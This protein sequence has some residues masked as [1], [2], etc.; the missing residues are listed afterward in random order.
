VAALVLVRLASDEHTAS[1][2][3]V[4]YGLSYA[5]GA[6]LSYLTLSRRVGG[7]RTRTLVRFLVRLLLA[8]A[9]AV[10]VAGGVTLVARH[11]PAADSLLGSVLQCAVIGAVGLGMLVVLARALRI[12]EVTEVVDTFARR[13]R[14]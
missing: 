13:L 11:V 14:R 6:T 7:L 4:A 5:V 1:A 9:G 3:T 8:A 10:L 2:L 12:S